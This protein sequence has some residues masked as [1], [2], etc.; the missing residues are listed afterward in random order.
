MNAGERN[1]RSKAGVSLTL[2]LAQA[3]G[4]AAAAQADGFKAIGK[5]LAKA[6]KR[7]GIGLVAVLPF[8]PADSSNPREGWNI[9]E[10]LTTQIVR[11]KRVQTVERNHLRKLMNE[12]FLG[13]SGAI[14]LPR[15]RRVGKILA[16]D[17]LVTG[18]F[19]TAGNEVV[20]SA[21]LIDA[22]TGAIIEAVERKA[23]R[24]WY[25]PLGLN[26]R[27]APMP[28]DPYAFGGPDGEA[29]LIPPAPASV[30]DLIASA[31]LRDSVGEAGCEDAAERVDRLEG[32]ILELKARY[33]ANQL[34]NGLSL[35][36]LRHNPG[37]TITDPFLK[38]RFYDRM[39]AW[40]AQ[41]SVPAMTA[42]EV[43]RFTEIDG[44]AFRL[45]RECGL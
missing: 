26:G 18:S 37:S 28:L 5:E 22:R 27:L 11:Q 3:L 44:Q 41:A 42:P 7:S 31:D 33:W 32:A 43:K 21:R 45:H 25:D 35:A 13:E 10:K 17:A 23:D 24:D 9:A 4:A 16:V 29:P 1:G 14:E 34:K 8:E 6:A 19:V 36:S 39:K 20:V 38:R 2:L 12:A 15:L 30:P 40:Y